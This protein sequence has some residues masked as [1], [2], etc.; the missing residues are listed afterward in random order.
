MCHKIGLFCKTNNV[1]PSKGFY[2][3]YFLCIYMPLW[4][5]LS[6][7]TMT[8]MLP[9]ANDKTQVD[10]E[11]GIKLSKQD[12][13]EYTIIQKNIDAFFTSRFTIFAFRVCVL[14][15]LFKVFLDIIYET[16]MLVSIA[17]GTAV[18]SSISRN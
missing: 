9:V 13:L 8:H 6:D 1:D 3:N 4:V 18:V 17:N 16:M 11:S 15:L 14:F 7:L 5:I 10:E 12:L 2:E